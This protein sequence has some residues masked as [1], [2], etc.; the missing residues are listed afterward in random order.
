MGFDIKVIKIEVKEDT[1]PSGKYQ[2]HQLDYEYKGQPGSLK[3]FSQ[4]I[5]K[6]PD[7]KEGLN[8]L[9]PGMIVKIDKAD[10]GKGYKELSKIVFE[11][12]TI[13]SP[14]LN[15]NA[16]IKTSAA[17]STN[18]SFDGTG[19]QVGNAITNACSTLKEGSTMKDI[20]NRVWEII[21]LG[22]RTKKRIQN[23][24]HI[25]SNLIPEN[26]PTMDD[27]AGHDMI[28]EEIPF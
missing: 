19:A 10:N 23:N 12:A 13:G 28:D 7:L 8:Q 21:L 1:G 4:T 3:V 25:K 22:E 17:L 24:E 11:E 16:H 6:Y 20:E 27:Q 5:K 15:S 9:K 2:Y 26:D 14:V 18:T